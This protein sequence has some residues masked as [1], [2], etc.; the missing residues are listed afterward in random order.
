M[1]RKKRT[2]VQCLGFIICLAVGAGAAPAAYAGAAAKMLVSHRAVYE[3]SLDQAD[4]SSHIASA[5]GRMVYEAINMGCEGL[6]VNQRVVF[7]ITFDDGLEA[8]SDLR[9][10][11]Y[12]VFDGSLFQFS[13]RRYFNSEISEYYDGQAVRQANGE[14]RLILKNGNKERT[15][16]AGV[17]FP[18]AYLARVIEAAM[19]EERF[20][21]SHVFD[22]SDLNQNLSATSIIGAPTA[23]GL[24][25]EERGAGIDAAP[26]KTALSWPVTISYFENDSQDSTPQFVISMQVFENGVASRV[27]FDYGDFQMAGKL[28]MLE[29]F[30]QE[31][32]F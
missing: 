8:L 26:L 15:L 23:P 2:L 7:D 20:F 27:Y 12:E 10:A 13:T 9:H 14:V 25:L 30:D 22:G 31:P 18:N 29:F 16:A 6:A 24:S 3:M 5:R 32:C 11:S 28:S 17:L 1:Y 19:Q 4:A 21:E